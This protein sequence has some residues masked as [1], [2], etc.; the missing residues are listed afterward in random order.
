[1]VILNWFWQTAKT[2]DDTINAPATSAPQIATQGTPTRLI[3][4]ATLPA[5]TLFFEQI[6][7]YSNKDSGNAVDINIAPV[8]A[9]GYTGKGVTIAVFDTAMD[10]GHVDL[11]VN[12]NMKK[13]IKGVDA[14]FIS[15]YG[16][17]HATAVAGIIAG[18]RNDTGIVGVA[19]DANITPINIFSENQSYSWNALKNQSSFDIA[20]HSWGFTSAFSS[21]L[22]PLEKSSAYYLSGFAAAAKT[23]RGG[24]G[25]LENIAAGNYREYGFSTQTNG[26]TVDR[27]VIV[28][29]ATD[30]LGHVS[31]YSNPGASLL[32]V[33]PSSGDKNGVTTSDVTGKYGYSSG[34]YTEEFGGTSAATPILSGIEAVM[35]EANS[36]LGW[37]DVQTILAITARHTGTEIGE[38]YK[39][40]ESEAWLVNEARQWNGGGFHFSNDYGFGLVDAEAAV[41]LA[42]AWSLVFNQPKRSSNELK[43]TAAISGSWSWGVKK[44]PPSRSSQK[45]AIVSRLS[46]SAA[47]SQR[48]SNVASYNSSSPSIMFA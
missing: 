6:N 29:G 35:L 31:Y 28:V 24:L 43:E 13:A 44:K 1:M 2:E 15:P 46:I 30:D 21:F 41:R 39:G 42:K 25:T 33:A 14:T 32:V 27:H 47:S 45:C 36:K 7:L 9:M 34:D 40:Y 37:R 5:D 12:V 17:E 8:W 26:L 20:N 48:R 3:D 22:N 10:V 38:G 4:Q 23:G 16:D 11:A 18:A 19:Y